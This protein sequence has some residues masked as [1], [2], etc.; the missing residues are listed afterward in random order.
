MAHAR[1]WSLKFGCEITRKPGLWNLANWAFFCHIRGLEMEN[2]I[3][4][5]ISQFRPTWVHRTYKIRWMSRLASQ[6]KIS[7]TQGSSLTRFVLLASSANRFGTTY[8]SNIPS[9][10]SQAASRQCVIFTKRASWNCSALTHRLIERPRTRAARTGVEP[11]F[12]IS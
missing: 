5:A 2:S 1:A 4:E 12:C 3:N 11:T 7:R 10:F 9:G 8:G 6:S